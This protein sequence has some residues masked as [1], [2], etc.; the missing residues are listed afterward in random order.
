MYW[1]DWHYR[2]W[3]SQQS[4]QPCGLV[5]KLVQYRHFRHPRLWC[6][7][8][9][10]FQS[11]RITEKW[12]KLLTSPKGN[13]PWLLC[14]LAQEIQR[15]W[16]EAK[17]SLTALKLRN[18]RQPI[19]PIRQIASRSNFSFASLPPPGCSST[20]TSCFFLSSS[21]S[22]ESPALLFSFTPMRYTSSPPA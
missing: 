12:N 7:C 9:K 16:V 14:I 18:V 1:P 11:I 6:H 4:S 17:Y 3:I 19:E 10:D 2:K 22:P 21:R 5:H 13:A 8:F 20:W 15:L